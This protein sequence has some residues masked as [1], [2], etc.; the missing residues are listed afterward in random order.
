MSLL[1]PS[2]SPDQTPIDSS[3]PSILFLFLIIIV[4]RWK[5]CVLIPT[6]QP[7]N[8]DFFDATR[9][10]LD[11]VHH[12]TSLSIFPLASQRCIRPSCKRFLYS[13]QSI[14][15]PVLSVENIS[16]HILIP[17]LYFVR[18]VQ[19]CINHSHCLLPSFFNKLHEMF[20]KESRRLDSKWPLP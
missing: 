16:K 15:K 12:S 10:P 6:T 18:E 19:S 14:T 2:V 7:F 1:V 3:K 20:M 17:I 4:N 13:Y 9:P 5:I 8:S 11:V